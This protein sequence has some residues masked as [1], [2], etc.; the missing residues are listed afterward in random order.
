MPEHPPIS[1]G[2]KNMST[3]LWK[4]EH[5]EEMRA[6]RRKHYRENRQQYTDRNKVRRA[7]RRAF[8]SEL[9]AKSCCSRC[10]E[11]DPRCLDFHHINPKEKDFTIAEVCKR[12]WSM[13]NI[14]AEIEKCIILCANCHRKEHSA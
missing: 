2:R 3:E 8:I 11:N 9:K 6:Y 4:Q 12:N 10:P 5:Q 13:E 1:F 14:C 7:E